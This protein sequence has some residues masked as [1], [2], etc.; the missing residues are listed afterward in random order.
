MKWRTKKWLY[1]YNSRLGEIGPTILVPVIFSI[2]ALLS[3]VGSLIITWI[4]VIKGE[5]FISV[6][7]Y[8]I[9]L[10]ILHV[11]I[12]VVGVVF[13]YKLERMS[14]HH[15]SKKIPILKKLQMIKE[16]LKGRSF[17]LIEQDLEKIEGSLLEEH[18]FPITEKTIKRYET[19]IVHICE[20]IKN[21]KQVE[22]AMVEHATLR[23]KEIA[24]E[25]AESIK[26]DED[27]HIHAIKTREAEIAQEWTE[28]YLKD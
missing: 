18:N 21:K 25:I 15:S 12:L 26:K 27:A 9:G 17:I 1:Q 16:F 23:A 19:E 11:I 3:V 28:V 14:K 22:L 24:K 6:G 13:P 5:A 10:F 7:N 4:E 20:I 8:V 2:F